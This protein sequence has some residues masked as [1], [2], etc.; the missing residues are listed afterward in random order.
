MFKTIKSIHMKTMYLA[1]QNGLIT[2]FNA[3]NNGV[4]IYSRKKPNG[5]YYGWEEFITDIIPALKSKIQQ[6]DESQSNTLEPQA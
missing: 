4:I 5:V 3:S 6:M 2:K 1:I